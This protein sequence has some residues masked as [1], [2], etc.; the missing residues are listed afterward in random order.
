MSSTSP[1]RA[2]RRRDRLI[3]LGVAGVI[4]AAIG[5]AALFGGLRARPSGPSQDTGPVTID[6]GRFKVRLVDARIGVTAGSSLTPGKRALIVRMRVSSK[7]TRSVS[8][9]DFLD[10]IIGEPKPG[11][12]VDPDDGSRVLINGLPSTEIHPRLPV[13]VEAYWPLPAGNSPATARIGVRQWVYQYGFTSPE[14]YW[15]VG[16]LSSLAAEVTMKVAQ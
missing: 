3:A 10:G 12:S 4:V 11:R 16:K 5:V 6:Q 1:D 9:S 14:G 15:Y 2:H 8:A 13:A 7:D